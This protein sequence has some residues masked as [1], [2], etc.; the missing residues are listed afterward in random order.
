MYVIVAGGGKVGSNVTRSLLDLG[1]E[2]TL[3]EQR[4]DRFA[5]LEEEFGPVVIRGDATEIAVLE[6]AGIARPPELLLAVTG[7]DEDNLV[8]SQIAKEAYGVRKAIARV[9]DPRNQQHFDLL[10]ITQTVCATTSILGLVEHEVPEH[11][12]VQLLELQKEGLVVVEVQVEG[13][14]P[15]AG[16]EGRRA[17][18][19]G[20]LAPHL[21]LPPGP[22]GARRAVDGAAARRPGAR[23]RSDDRGG[24]SPPRAPRRSEVAQAHSAHGALTRVGYRS[25]RVGSRARG[26]SA[27]S[28]SLLA[29]SGSALGA[30]SAFRRVVVARGLVE[31]VQV[32]APRSEARRLYVVEQRGTIRVID[33]GR[34][35]TGFFLDVA[36]D[37][38]TA[39]GE[40]GLLGL[41]FDPK[42][43]T[44]RFIYVELHGHE[45]RH[46]RRSLPDERHA[47]DPRRARACSS[48]STSRTRTTTAASSRSARTAA[49][50]SASAT[51][52]RAAI[53]RTAR[54]TCSSL[55]GKM[56]RL[57]VRRPGSAPEIVGARPAQPVALL[58]RPRAPATSTSATSARATSRRSTTRRVE[59]RARELRL[60]PLRGLAPLRGEGAPAP[61]SSSSRSSSTPTTRGC[62]VVGGYVYRGQG[63]ARP[64]AAGTSS[65]TTAR[66]RLEPP[67]R[68]AARRAD[69]RT[70]PFRSRASPRSA[71]TPRASSSRRHTRAIVSTEHQLARRRTRGGACP[72]AA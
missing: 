68:A 33:R 31:P 44:N 45:R 14:S 30:E 58:V 12:L 2:V 41:A 36:R 6:R 3:I 72:S 69:V 16:Q 57:D 29:V 27:P 19:P 35:R 40:Q 48:A 61:G 5:R 7:D 39:G 56:L 71:R 43:A 22:D 53:P 70:E 46:A 10:G 52:A 42:Y 1:H 21:G 65:A 66:D 63:A 28:S 13:G 47:R 20:G 62:T 18:A 32:T 38:S 11:G 60:G 8:I 24:G 25:V 55:L 17:R 34:L 54:R 37:A 64:S 23:D 9:N 26:G 15:A 67:R 50:T 49:C 4:P 51:A 59:R